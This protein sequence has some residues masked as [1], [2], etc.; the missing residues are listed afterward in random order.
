MSIRTSGAPSGSFNDVLTKITPL[1]PKEFKRGDIYYIDRAGGAI[2]RQRTKRGQ[3]GG[4]CIERCRKQTQRQYNRG[5]SHHTAKKRIAD[6]HFH[7]QFAKGIYCIVRNRNDGIKAACGQ[8]LRDSDTAGN[9]ADRQGVSRRVGL[10]AGN[11]SNHA[12][13][14]GRY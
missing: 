9:A 7:Q 5:I 6:T 10:R 3:T 11:D 12:G 13:G 8:L 4:Y 2:G 14:A 1:L